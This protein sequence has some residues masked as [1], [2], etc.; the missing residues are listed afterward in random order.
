MIVRLL[1]AY[2]PWWSVRSQSLSSVFIVLCLVVC[3][4][5]VDRTNHLVFAWYFVHWKICWRSSKIGNCTYI[6]CSYEFE[7]V[8]TIDQSPHCLLSHYYLA[9]L[10][11]L[12]DRGESYENT[13]I[14]T[15]LVPLVM[16]LRWCVF[17][18]RTIIYHSYDRG[19]SYE[20]T[21]IRTILAPLVMCWRWC[22]FGNR[23]FINHSYD[24]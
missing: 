6:V 3:T 23:T 24:Y 18:N 14:R 11:R 7:H 9:M 15:I 1:L 21:S 5:G 22:V 20:I 19:E 2:D 16:C 12:Y 17:S 10:D 4:I 8:C 13:S